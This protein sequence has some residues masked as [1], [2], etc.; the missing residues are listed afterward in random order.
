[1]IY[2]KLVIVIILILLVNSV[3]TLFFS[4]NKQVKII[5]LHHNI[6]R[7]LI[8]DHYKPYKFLTKK[9]EQ[10]RNVLIN[11]TTVILFYGGISENLSTDDKYRLQGRSICNLSSLWIQDGF[12]QVII[13]TASKIN[14]PNSNKIII[15]N[16]LELTER[17]YNNPFKL[18]WF[19]ALIPLNS[20][21]YVADDMFPNKPTEVCDKFLFNEHEIKQ[22]GNSDSA[23]INSANLLYQMGGDFINTPKNWP[24]H[25]PQYIKHNR[26][27]MV[28]DM[29]IDHHSRMGHRGVND[30]SFI[31][32]YG[33][34]SFLQGDAMI[35]DVNYFLYTNTDNIKLFNHSIKKSKQ[36]Y[37]INDGISRMGDIEYMNIVS[38]IRI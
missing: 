28:W 21:L 4:L 32:A 33:I 9:M 14:C 15:I 17:I 24:Y 23:Y 38:E 31:E 35:S 1:M 5:E 6:K 3:V 20:F 27:K 12:F 2:N 26:A 36:Y 30:Y 7:N 34:L 25:G 22:Y 19:L 16:Q 18:E 8:D 29:M 10:C 13:Y 11:E 37:C